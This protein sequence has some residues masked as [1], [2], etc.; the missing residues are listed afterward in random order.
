MYLFRV[1]PSAGSVGT[2]LASQSS[3][4][5]VFF[6]C[7]TCRRVFLFFLQNCHVS[8]FHFVFVGQFLYES[9]M[10]EHVAVEQLLFQVLQ[11]RKHYTAHHKRL[12]APNRKYVP[13]RERQRKQADKSWRASILS[14]I[15]TARWGLKTKKWQSAY[16]ENPYNY[17]YIASVML[18]VFALISILVQCNTAPSLRTSQVLIVHVCGVRVVLE[19]RGL[20]ICKSSPR[21]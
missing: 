1:P 13:I 7:C 14:S 10:Y 20:V 12:T 3:H 21:T 19:E 2:Y 15:Y 9:I 6:C 4:L 8:S 5:N 18:Q 16:S 17:T 11:H